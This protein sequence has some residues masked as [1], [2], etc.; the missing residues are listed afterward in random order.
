MYDQ[1][2]SNNQNVEYFRSK[3]V[4]IRKYRIALRQRVTGTMSF[5]FALLGF[6]LM[7]MENEFIIKSVYDK[8]VLIK[9]FFHL[10][11]NFDF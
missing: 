2:K 7:I 3:S 11:I 9:F 6:I 8:V 1:V 5:V 4:F 10:N